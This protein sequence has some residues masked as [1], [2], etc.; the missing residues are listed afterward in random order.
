MTLMKEFRTPADFWFGMVEPDFAD[1]E[2]NKADLRAAFHAAI[3]LYHMHDWVW[4]ARADE[5]KLLFTY[6]SGDRKMRAVHGARSFANALEQQYPDFGR[7]RSIANAAKH[8]E[9]TEIRP[10]ENAASHASNTAV[11]VPGA[12]LGGYGIGAGYGTPGLSYA[13]LPRVMLAGPNG[14]DIEFFHLAKTVRDMWT[15]LRASHGWW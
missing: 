1:C 11:Q 10:V 9:L 13:G 8:L 15:G 14:N 2:A 12:G 3:S 5:V 6:S 7:I 4:K